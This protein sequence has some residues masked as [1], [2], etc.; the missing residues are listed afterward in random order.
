MKRS[1]DLGAKKLKCLLRF[2]IATRDLKKCKGFDNDLLAMTSL[3]C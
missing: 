2:A 1:H 3:D